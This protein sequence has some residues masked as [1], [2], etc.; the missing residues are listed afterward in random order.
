MQNIGTTMTPEEKARQKIDQWFAEAGWKVINREDYEPTSTAVA[1]REGLLK[2]NLEA[3]YFLFINGKAVGVLEAKRE[4]IDALSDKVCAQ[5]ALY[6][7]SVP[8]IYQTY[9]N[10][11]PF[12]FTSN[13]KNLYFCDF[14]KQEQ[15]FKQIMAIPTPYD[16]VKQ[17][18]ISDY[19]AGLPTLQKKGLR[20]CQYEA[21]TELEKSFRSGQNR[22]LMVLATGAGKTYTACLAAYRLLSYTPMRRIL[23]LVDRNNLGKQAEG[24]FGTF[25]LTENGDAFNTIFTVNRLRSSSIPSDSNVIISTIQRLFSFLKGDTIDD[26]DE[27]EGNEPAEEIILPPNPNLP[28]DYFDLIIIDE[29]HRSI[30]GNWRKVLEYFDTARLV[31]LTATPV[32]ETMAFFNNNRI[33][34][35]T[36]EKS[37]VDGVNVDCR[38]YR[39]RT[40]VTENG[41]AILKGEKVKEETRYTGDIKTI[42]NKEAKTYTSKELNRSVINP[43]QIK[44]VLSTYR[45]VVYTELFNDP[46][47]EANFDWLPKT[48][49][50]AL[51]E[52]HATNIVQIAKEVFGRTDDRFVQKITYSAGDSNELI[53]QFRNDKDFRIA[54]TCTLVA[55]GTDIK[56]LEVVMFMRDVESLPL[57]IQMKG[58]GVRTIGDE[59]LRNVTPNAF[60]K[61]CFFLVDAVGVTE[62]EKTIP[63][64]AD[65][66]TT[67]TI[68][69]KELLERISHGYLP[70]EYLQRLAA[71]LSR[72]Y[73]KADNSQRN[74]FTRLAHDDMKELAS[75]IYDALDNNPL[76]PFINI[77]EPN[78]ERKGLVAPLANHANARR[79]LLILS[80]GFVNTLMPGEDT[81]ISKGFSIEEA[82]NTTEAF[83]EFCREHTD[84]I[85][86]LRIIYNNEGEPI[87]YSMLKDLENKLKM[88]NNHFTSK[89]LWN[90]Y[91]ILNPNSVRRS[92]TKEESDALTN[93]IQLVR[94]AFR[95]IERLDSVVTTS[96]QYFNLWL[97]QNQREITDKQREVISRIVDYIAS[98]GACT[99]KDIRE[100]DATHAAQMIRAFG[101]MQ[102]ANDALRSLYTFVVLGKSA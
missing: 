10:P 2:G 3:D 18:G 11:L 17:L 99:V 33:V 40:Q 66:P 92:T 77:N 31:G 26:D 53:R 44:L 55:T 6:A 25:R 97:G 29:C 58:R 45:D 21:V 61:D 91:A 32:P 69:F 22:A 4:D 93:I 72:I 47:R 82:Q 48:L 80:A 41:G 68:T 19:F 28:H 60:S 101:N 81:L 71:T 57:Y 59:Q 51:N 50:F 87:T 83:E 75:R 9:Q 102:K 89:Q 5:A 27:D 23:F 30:Y 1:I 14:R 20:D 76:P 63:T 84:E 54:V 56:P 85:E 96:K 52:T 100:D 64:A 46:Q 65:E 12:I 86:A 73:N 16:L 7:K 42:F 38:V 36:L 78:N 34:N 74:E 24:E 37:I 62:H 39:I 13:G 49:I 8:H 95:Q 35:Y 43:A 70:D 79:Y 67:K 88:A 94:Y 98:N 90:S 15:S